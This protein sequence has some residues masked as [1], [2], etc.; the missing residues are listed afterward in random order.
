MYGHS[1]TSTGTAS[2]GLATMGYHGVA[3]IL[4]VITAIFAAI[5]VG[6]LLRRQGKTRP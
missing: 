4:A 5:A 3:L 6:Q 2:A 1:A